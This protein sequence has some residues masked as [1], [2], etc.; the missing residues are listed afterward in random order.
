MPGGLLQGVKRPKAQP[1]ELIDSINALPRPAF[2][3]RF[4]PPRSKL[5]Q[6]GDYH[7]SPRPVADLD[8]DELMA[9]FSL[10]E[11]TSAA[12]YKKSP[13][14]WH[15]NAKQR[16]M[17]EDNM[18]YL[19]VRKAALG[20]IV[21][22]LSFMFT[23]ED[24][25]PVVYIYEIHL[26]EE[27]RGAG[28]GKHLMRIVDL[29]AAEGAVDKVMLTCFRSNAV[30][31][32]F[33]ERLGFG[34]DEFSP[35]AKRLRGGKI[36]V[37]PYLIMSKSVEEDHAKAVANISAA[38]RAFHDR[39]EKFRISHGSTNST[40]QSATRRKT[41]FIDTSGLSHVLKVD[42]EARTAL[43]QPNV[44]M[45]RL[46]EETMKHGLIPPVI[47]EFPGITVGG[48]YSGT[49]GESSSFKYGYFDRTIN[50][51]EMVLA[52]GQ[53]VRCSRTELPDLFHGA[54]GAVG[55]FGVTTLVEL[56]LKPA[57]KFVETTYHPVSSV[58]EAVSLSEQLIAQPDT[59]DYV[60]GIL[61]SKTSGVII[62]GRATDTP[63]PTAPI[64]TFSA[65]RDPWF[66]L[67]AQDR[68]KAGRAA[69]DAVPLAEYLF[70]YDRGGFWV[71][72]S[73]FEYFHFPFTAATRALLDDFLHTRM[74]YAAL[75]AS[76]QSR[77]YVVQ[78][79]ALPFSTAERFIDYT[80]ATFD[81]WPLWLCPL[82]QS[83]GNTMHPHNATDLEEVP[84]VESGTTRTRRRP[85][86]NVGLWGWAPRHAQ[87]DPDA[88]AALNRDLE[89]TLRELGGMK[90]LYAHTYYTEDEF[91]RT[92]KNRDWYEAL[93]R[94]YG[95]EGLPS[96]YEKVRVD[97]GEEKR[98]RAEA[99]WARRLLDVW[100]VGGV[101]AIRRAIKSGLYW[102]HR[103]A[104]WNKHGAGGKE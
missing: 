72:R 95:A 40:R 70:R 48:G 84:D 42:V 16:E 99:G 65:P 37:P 102:R 43:V 51:V 3:A 36:K 94:K 46:A 33:Y 80:A 98:L 31:L 86:L 69:T 19:L 67:H 66:Y 22:F 6:H 27:H 85:L 100:P 11:T 93:R 62:T 25:Y 68:I 63:A 59:H 90:W 14:G 74:L 75:H 39:G 87:N 57:K 32:A 83:D 5:L 8:H 21:A 44:P 53:V 56:Q 20:E 49:S 77:R 52:N 61:F 101:Y 26:A 91:W 58:A 1:E 82:R 55:T 50:W 15:P 76:G 18:H 89:A 9:C 41:N 97:V 34:E 17:R 96:V 78:D 12:D 104:V 4:F 45:D 38:V 2:S 81:I 28:L 79:L 13:R 54:A 23:I 60:D 29:C 103:D 35:P 71:G 10:I 92:Y 88:F 47:M 73:A 7:V 24:D 64:Q 30:A